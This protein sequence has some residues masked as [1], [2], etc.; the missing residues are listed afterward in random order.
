[1]TIL[2]FEAW[3]SD[4]YQA[5][6]HLSGMITRNATLRDEVLSDVVERCVRVGDFPP[7]D[8]G[9]RVGWFRP[10]LAHAAI[11]RAS[12]EQ[13]RARLRERFASSLATLGPDVYADTSRSKAA[14]AT[15]RMKVNRSMAAPASS[16]TPRAK[17]LR[18][19]MVEKAETI[20]SHW[21]T[22]QCADT[23]WVYQQRRDS[24]LFDAQAL[25]SLGEHIRGRS[26]R[27][28]R[29]AGR[30]YVHWGLEVAMDPRVLAAW[31]NGEVKGFFEGG[32][33][34][35]SCSTGY[36]FHGKKWI[37][38]DSPGTFAQCGGCGE[39]AISGRHDKAC[40]LK[41]AAA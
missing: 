21:L 5:L 29:G 2:E 3:V 23:R 25:Q 35:I 9:D 15:R 36:Q 17:L 18:A 30:S 14:A 39:H 27:S 4:N 40:A 12:S 22:G 20:A 7:D 13:A 16:T 8:Y 11:D 26:S 34:Q 31:R 41:G 10:R 38:Q 19:R 33:T 24:T 6:R 37:G 28:L 32:W 1:M